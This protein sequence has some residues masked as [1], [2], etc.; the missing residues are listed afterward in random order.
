MF[1]MERSHPFRRY[2]F[3]M[4][5]FINLNFM[6]VQPKAAQ[7]PR[8][9]EKPYSDLLLRFLSRLMLKQRTRPLGPITPRE[10]SGILKVLVRSSS[11]HCFAASANCFGWWDHN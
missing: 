4:C 3:G 9:N 6:A 5:F 1:D 2:Y 10:L 7:S 8:L 11:S